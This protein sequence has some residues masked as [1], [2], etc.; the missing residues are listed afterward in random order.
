MTA[1][2]SAGSERTIVLAPMGRDAQIAAAILGE[3][4]IETAICPDMASLLPAVNAGAGLALIVEEVLHEQDYGDFARWVEAQPAWS[5]FPVIVLAQR[6]GGI[7]RNPAA[8]RFIQA[9]GNVSF[10]ERPFHPT[11]L[12]SIVQ[13]ALRGRRRQYEARERLDTLRAAVRRQQQD[14]AHLRLLINE[15]NHRVKNTLATVQSLVA[16]TLRSAD[17]STRTRDALTSRIVALSKAHDVLTNE[18]W[19]GADLAEIAGQAAQPFRLGLGEERILMRGPHVRVPPKT[20]I[21]MALALHELA[22]NAVKY[23]ALSASGG[24][25]EF[26]WRLSGRAA[27]RELIAVWRELDGP[28]VSPPT[29]AGFG[30]RLIA[31]GLA[32]DLNGEV[33][34]HYP[35]EG[36]VCTIRA[37]LDA[38]D[39]D[40]VEAERPPGLRRR[41]SASSGDQAETPSPA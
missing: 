27:S 32:A 26:T 36:V 25:V 39:L 17:V 6:G 22:T 7:E 29:R 40:A 16:Q 14:Q 34:I 2:S 21:A 37:R 23:G 41:P 13:T 5:D 20:A 28:R 18:Q 15:L 3:A 35:A 38:A 30:T 33:T 1:A 11:T 31:R 9:L 12:V 8:G 4:K 10:L 19:A 24:R